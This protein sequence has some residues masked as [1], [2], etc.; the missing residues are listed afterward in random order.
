M[1]KDSETTTWIPNPYPMRAVRFET[2]LWYAALIVVPVMLY[3]LA[4]PFPIIL[5]DPWTFLGLI[6]LAGVAAFW[7]HYTNIRVESRWRPEEISLS[8]Q[9]IHCR[10]RDERN[11]IISW[12]EIR[13]VRLIPGNPRRET[14]AVLIGLDRRMMNDPALFEE[15]AKAVKTRFDEYESQPGARLA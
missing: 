6:A 12:R 1:L 4:Y 14:Q 2:S 11:R 9:G 8:N 13:Q 3:L 15:A 7:S 10:Y 5:R